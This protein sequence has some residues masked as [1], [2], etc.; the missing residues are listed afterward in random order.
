MKKLYKRGQKRAEKLTVPVGGTFV[1]RYPGSI[2]IGWEV[3]LSR[4]DGSRIIKRTFDP[5]GE[6]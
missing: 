1:L 5:K 4:K 6:G 3:V 2:P